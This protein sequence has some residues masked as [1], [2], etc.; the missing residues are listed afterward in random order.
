VTLTALAL[1][2]LLGGAVGVVS[3]LL[4][5]GGGILMVPFL[6]LLM[7]GS[8]WSGLSVP[9]EHQAALA[10][11]TSLAVIVP[12][13][14][15]GLRA[16]HRADAIRWGIILPL[17]AAA[18]VTA[19]LGARVAVE[20]STPVLKTIFGL[21]IVFV[22]ARSIRRRGGSV[23]EGDS[24]GEPLRWWAALVGGGL[25]GFMSALLGVGGGVVAIPILIHWARL[26]LHRVVP[27]SIAII[28]FAAPAGVLSYV[29][30]GW[31][32][33]ELPPGSMGFVHLPSALALIPGAVL[34]APVGA[35]WNQ[36][37]PASTLRPL[38]GVLLLVLGIQL[39]W[40]HGGWLF[41]SF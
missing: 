10:H 1:A 28:V 5:I 11:A 27:A 9:I 16:F 6:Y 29:T 13:A 22:G 21:F 34:L 8:T 26:D 25:V 40:A 32:L 20:L 38:F 33:P 3:G 31:G 15:S 19:L 18:A 23:S 41:P 30:A 17:G 36:R 4:G 14:L 39:V 2:L 12:T 37:L 24:G 35:R 7:G